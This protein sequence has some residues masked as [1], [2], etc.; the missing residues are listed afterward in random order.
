MIKDITLTVQVDRNDFSFKQIKHYID[1]VEQT[2]N[3]F[4]NHGLD[5]DMKEILSNKILDVL[6]IVGEMSLPLFKRRKEIEE[7]WSRSFPDDPE[8][9]RDGWLDEYHKLHK[10]YDKIKDRAYDLFCKINSI[11]E[12]DA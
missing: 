2:Y 7:K 6:E 1:K 11:P 10:P 8:A 5:K 9:A 3:K 12:K 4:L